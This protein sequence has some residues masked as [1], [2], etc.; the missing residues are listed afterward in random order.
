MLKQSLIIFLLIVL[1]SSTAF[2]EE[3]R[4]DETHPFYLYQSGDIE[5][6]KAG[7]DKELAQA[8]K[9]GKKAKIWEKLMSLAWFED[10]TGKHW[11]S[12]THSNEALELAKQLKN[13]FMQGRT[14]SWLGWAY[15]HLGLYEAAIKFYEQSIEL[16]TKDGKIV[17][18]PLW[19]LST[20]EL[21]AIHYKMGDIPRAKE[22]L[23]K[24]TN[25]AKKN[26]IDVGI[27]EGGAHLAE[28]SLTEGN[29]G[30][31]EKWAEEAVNAAVRCGCSPNNLSRALVSKAKVAFEKYKL[32][33]SKRKLVEDAISEALNQATTTDNKRYVAEGKL[34]SSK[35]SN[36]SFQE[37][38][39]LVSS[40]FET[41][42][43][44]ESEERG[45][46]E[47]ELGKL[48]LE[49]NQL[50]LAE[51]YLKN[52]LDINK[53]LL[54]KLDNGFIL[55]ELSIVSALSRDEQTAMERL[56]ESLKIA[57]ETGAKELQH[58]GE[59]ALMNFHNNL[60]YTRLAL[61]YGEEALVSL[62]ALEFAESDQT[63]KEALH[64]KKLDLYQTVSELRLESSSDFGRSPER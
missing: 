50:A 40:A 20:Q 1:F 5:G 9:A 3:K 61:Q 10:E 43:E 19:G 45:S 46:M 29:L 7:Y 27:A 62:N 51:F 35:I 6:A 28:L 2:A 36:G 22:L 21:G 13:D 42:A 4:K 54:R 38:F 55:S 25:F 12:I 31:A 48:F 24:T 32:D 30:E 33:A 57:K 41:L 16:G 58:Q 11:D 52:G 37:R 49:D 18:V 15:A 64:A 63:K 39:E 26:G 8:R 17:H 34:L 53:E 23:L 56:K 44:I 60:G 47:A 14:L 59:F